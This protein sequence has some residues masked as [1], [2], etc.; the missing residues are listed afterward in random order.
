MARQNTLWCQCIVASKLMELVGFLE[1]LTK[2]QKKVECQIRMW[3]NFDIWVI[4]FETYAFKNLWTCIFPLLTFHF[5]TKLWFWWTHFLNFVSRGV[6]LMSIWW[7]MYKL[8][9]L[10]LVYA[11][12]WIRSKMQV[13]IT[14]LSIFG[15]WLSMSRV[16]NFQSMNFGGHKKNRVCWYLILNFWIFTDI[17]LMQVSWVIDSKSLDSKE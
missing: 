5:A 1:G 10:I 13:L 11:F 3:L 7:T 15:F 2:L 9:F 4:F 12:W 16:V 6:W 14:W 8:G 17:G